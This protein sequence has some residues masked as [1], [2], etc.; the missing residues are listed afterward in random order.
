MTTSSE[1]FANAHMDQPPND[2]EFQIE[3]KKNFISNMIIIEFM[4]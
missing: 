2:K 3:K 4:T 1:L